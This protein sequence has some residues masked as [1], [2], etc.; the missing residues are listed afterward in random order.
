MKTKLTILAV[1][2]GL[3]LTMGVMQV[4]AGTQGE[5]GIV[6]GDAVELSTL[7]MKGLSEDTVD[8]M[9][10]RAGQGFPVGIIEE[11]TGTLWIAVYRNNAP[12]SGLQPGNDKL[13]DYLGTKVVVQGLKY[14][15]GGVNV[16]R[17]SNVSE[18]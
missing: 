18:Y 2:L 3:A 15:N 14:K 17:F 9:K 5:K 12:A 8:E 6:V 16:I 1:V 10:N 11:E 7:G 13:S 4:N